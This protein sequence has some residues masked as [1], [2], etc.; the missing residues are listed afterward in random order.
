MDGDPV[1]RAAQELQARL[2]QHGPSAPIEPRPP[3]H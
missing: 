1:W 3:S 2:A